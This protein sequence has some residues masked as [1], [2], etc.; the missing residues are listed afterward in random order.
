MSNFK[1]A[2]FPFLY[3]KHWVP[4]LGETQKVLFH[5]N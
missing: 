5:F 4:D 3:N 2:F 1:V